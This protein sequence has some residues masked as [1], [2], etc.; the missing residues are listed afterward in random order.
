MRREGQGRIRVNKS[1]FETWSAKLS[2]AQ[3]LRED[4]H[5][6]CFDELTGAITGEE[7]V[8]FLRRLIDS[9]CVEDDFGVYEGLYNA[10]W[11]FPGEVTAIELA[12]ALPKWVVPN[13][14]SFF[15]PIFHTP[16]RLEAFTQTALQWKADVRRQGCKHIFS[17]S[18]HSAKD[19]EDWKPVLA[20]LGSELV[21]AM[22]EDSVPEHWPPEL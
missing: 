12:L 5:F 9:I 2:E 6:K 11:R 13:Q 16:Q 19:E 7:D 4:V 21:P 10:M 3:G 22:P 17:W 20:A 8:A 14:N 15:R 1:D 18:W